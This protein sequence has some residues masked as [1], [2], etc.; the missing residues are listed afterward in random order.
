MK[1]SIT[2]LTLSL[3]FLIIIGS[4]SSGQAWEKSFDLSLNATQ[5]SY[6]NSWV[7]GEAGNVTWA[8]SGNGI[9]AKQMSPKFRLR[10]TIKLAFGQT[11]SQDK[12][13]KTW[14]KPTK[15]TDKIDLEALGLFTIEA[16]VEPYAA[17]RFESQFLDA[18]VDANKRYINPV[19]LTES[20]GIAKQILKRE[21]DDVLTRLGF[22]VKQNINRDVYIYEIS[23]TDTTVTVETLT[24]TDGGVES[25]TDAKMVLSDK[26]GYLGKLTLYKAL[27]FSKKDDFKGTEAEDYW[28]AVDINW[29][30]T[31]T[32]SVSKYV[33][34][35]LYLQLLYDKQ[36][37]KKGRL[38]ET[39]AL[40]LTYKLL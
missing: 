39:L 32:A 34:V 23:P 1:P 33:Q 11:I 25:V 2:F 9:F 17:V 4:P 21:K 27:F 24:S 12:D 8:A 31:L 3:A 35:S 36:I 10:N 15:S 20:A 22:A 19:L 18:S 28:K 40:G 37:S 7:G 5:S 14:S 26:L 16:Y 30:N 38:K 29:E 6:S 13:D